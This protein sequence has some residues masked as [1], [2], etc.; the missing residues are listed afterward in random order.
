MIA[1]GLST[2][3][4]LRALRTGDAERIALG[5]STVAGIRSFKGRTS[6]DAVTHYAS[7]ALEVAR[8]SGSP[9]AISVALTSRGLARYLCGMYVE[10]LHDFESSAELLREQTIGARWEID[11]TEVY[12]AVTL[13]V[14]GRLN[15]LDCVV[16]RLLTEAVQGGDEYLAIN[17]RAMRANLL[18]LVRDAPEEGRW[19]V[20][21][22]QRMTR[23]QSQ[24]FSLSDFYYLCA[25]ANI[26]LYQGDA[27][28]ARRRVEEAWPGLR[29]SHLL[30]IQRIH[31]EVAFLRIRTAVALAQQL[32]ARRAAL[33]RDAKRTIGSLKGSD[34]REA[35]ASL[36]RAMIAAVEKTEEAMPPVT[37]ALLRLDACGLA[38]Y[39]HAARLRFGAL[40]GAGGEALR[41]EA[42][43]YMTS[44]R[45]T[46][47][48]ALSRVFVPV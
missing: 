46:N 30:G 35:L 1:R 9:H 45:V 26:D 6:H 48:V 7:L 21:E 13:V 20:E 32:P 15:E 11:I 41:S 24:R 38:L 3:L 8:R 14:L 17:L 27:A 39:A 43:A 12:R 40:L 44:Q 29:R 47:P 42:D 36:G 2:R 34:E 19:Y 28:S 25:L 10:A 22:A 16:S 18:W 4:I 5:L 23:A 33:F 37:E 31:T